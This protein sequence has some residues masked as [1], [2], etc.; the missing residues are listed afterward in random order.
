MKR[1]ATNR[2]IYETA[3]NIDITINVMKKALMMSIWPGSRHGNVITT[4]SLDGSFQYYYYYYYV[5]NNANVC[6][7]SYCGIDMCGNNIMRKIVCLAWSQT[8]LF[9]YWVAM[10]DWRKT[11]R[12]VWVMGEREKWQLSNYYMKTTDQCGNVVEKPDSNAMAVK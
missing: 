1:V 2:H 11:W 6:N 12:H 10:E 3:N 7:V 9:R 4:V 5:D 8:M